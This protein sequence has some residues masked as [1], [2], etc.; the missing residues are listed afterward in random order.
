MVPGSG[1]AQASKGPHSSGFDE[2]EPDWSEKGKTVVFPSGGHRKSSIYQIRV[3]IAST[4]S[5]RSTM[6]GASPNVMVNDAIYL[7]ISLCLECAGHSICTGHHVSHLCAYVAFS[8]NRADLPTGKSMLFP[9]Q[10]T[11]IPVHL[12]RGMEGLGNPKQEHVIECTLQWAPLPITPPH[13]FYTYHYQLARGS[14]LSVHA[15]LLFAELP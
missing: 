12:P 3:Q 7:L 10:T 14:K 4:T 15:S 9:S 6:R 5:T 1:P 11:L 2:M 13:S 8:M